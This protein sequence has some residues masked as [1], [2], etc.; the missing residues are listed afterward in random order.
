M[1]DVVLNLMILENSIETCIFPHE[2]WMTSVCSMHE[3][4]HSKPV[5]WDNPEVWGGEGGGSVDQD[6]V[7][8]VRPWL[9]LVYVWQGPPQCCEVIVLLF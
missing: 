3:A 1:L 9:I 7:A 2:K 5:L 4:G 6:G 8:H